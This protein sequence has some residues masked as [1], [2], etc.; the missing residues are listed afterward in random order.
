[1]ALVDLRN[2]PFTQGFYPSL[3]ETR[4]LMREDEAEEEVSSQ[5]FVLRDANRMEDD[6]YVRRLD[7]Q[8]KMMRRLFEIMV[9]SGC[10]RLAMLDGLSVNRSVLDSRDSVWK[11]LVS[12]GILRTGETGDSQEEGGTPDDTNQA[13]EEAANPIRRGKPG[14]YEEKENT[15]MSE[16]WHA[17]DSF[18]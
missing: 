8:T 15:R 14:S 13:E 7:G 17:E 10:G 18:A 3:T 6:K 5:P 2:N 12:A 4:L 16:P 9:L 11:A 1:L